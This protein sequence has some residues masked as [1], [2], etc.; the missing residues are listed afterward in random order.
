[1]RISKIRI[2]NYRSIKDSG[3]ILFNDNLFVIAGQN[4]SGKSSILEALRSFE[5]SQSTK[6]TLNFE[7]EKKE[8]L[9]QSI[10][11]TYTNLTEDFHDSIL[12][13][14]AGI[15]I[16]SDPNFNTVDPGDIIHED[17]IKRIKEFTITKI[18]DFTSGKLLKK[19]L[20]DKNVLN[21]IKNILKNEITYKVND[22]T[23]A[24]DKKILSE[25]LEKSI[26]TIIGEFL[27]NSPEII[28]F[29]DFTTLLP[30]KILL[31]DLKNKAADGHKAVMNLEGLLN[32]TFEKIASKNTPQKI[33]A[34]DSESQIISVN[35]QKDWQQKIY[36]TNDVKLKFF[37]E[38]NKSG[39]PE[40]S[41]YVET[42]ES[43]FLEPRKRS[44]GMIWF[45]SLW[46]ELKAKEDFENLIFLFDEPGLHLHIKAHNDMLS[47]FHK[48][49][50][51]GH[52]IIYST[53]SPSLIETDYLHNI[54]LVINDK[55]K[56]TII[57]GLTT[58][59]INT[60]NKRDALQPIAEAMGLD[61]ARNFSIINQRNVLVE[62]LSDFWY[63][64][65][66][67]KLLKIEK[68]YEFVPGVG[69]KH[70]KMFSLISMCIGYGLDWLLIMDKGDIPQQI[71]DELSKNLFNENDIEAKKKI[72]ILD[73]EIENIFAIKDVISID[74]SIKEKPGKTSL[75]HIGRKRKI[76][77]AK[78]FYQKVM[79][80]EVT[81]NDIE[82]STINVFKKIFKWIDMQFE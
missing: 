29:N 6:D 55:T 46:L 51:K 40:I 38:N 81:K 44:K 28:F 75:Q 31:T 61:I 56:G 41:F 9:I 12:T 79:N 54:G 13:F 53:H 17:K 59:R 76:V 52:Q 45:L 42:L 37:I 22:D 20:I 48:L 32:T 2:K 57:E 43:Q 80:D 25:L 77:F 66:M 49:I 5:N 69:I 63:F 35:F 62:G 74:D 72:M 68:D 36:G 8:Q 27:T 15:F 34:A 64:K 47:V 58:S 24:F 4:E 19:I 78:L 33:S 60:T 1:M 39:L 26:T 18:F 7:M 67:S 3:D 14:I 10:S 11:C 50:S 23:K 82:V 65:G 70:N 21:I 30:D 16:D 71:Y 73:D